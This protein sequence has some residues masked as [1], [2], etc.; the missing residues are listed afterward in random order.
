MPVMSSAKI[1]IWRTGDG[2]Y[3]DYSN[4]LWAGG[5][6]LV[7]KTHGLNAPQRLTFALQDGV[8][9][10]QVP[11]VGNRIRLTTTPYGVTFVGYLISVPE[12]E[13]LGQLPSG[14][15]AYGYHCV[16]V[17]EE[18][19]LEWQTAA[20]F[21]TLPPF[22]NKYQGEIIAE[23][24]TIL[25][26]GLT[27]TNIDNGIL[28]PY[29]RVRPEEG[30][31]DA[32]RR[33]SDRT[34]M[35]FW[36]ANGAAYY[37]FF[38]NLLSANREIDS[39]AWSKS[40]LSVSANSQADENGMMTAERVTPTVGATNAGVWQNLSSVVIGRSYRA[41]FLLKVPSGTVNVRIRLNK[42]SINNA[43][44]T[45]DIVVTSSWAWY[46]ILAT[47]PGDATLVGAMLG[48]DASWV[49]ADGPID[50][51]AILLTGDAD[52]PANPSE[53]DSQFDPAA[54][55]VS[56]VENPVYN[57]VIAVGAIEPQ[58][59]VR[60]YFIGD[61]LTGRFPLKFPMFGA[62]SSKLLEDDF[63]AALDANRWTETD[64]DSAISIAS[65]SLR[66]Q[67]SS[68]SGNNRL[69]AKQGVEIAGVV[70]LRSGRVRFNAA[71]SLL[72]GGLF[73]SDTGLLANCVAGFLAAP[74]GGQSDLRAVVS[75][76]AAGPTYT[77]VAG[78]TYQFA[79]TMNCPVQVRRR[80]PFYSITSQFGGE[81]VS[82]NA[83]VSFSVL[84]LPDNESDKPTEVL[85]YS[86]S[87]SGIAR[88]L[89]FTE[90]AGPVTTPGSAD[91]NANFCLL[92][93][94]IT[95]ELWT[96][97]TADAGYVQR[98]L[99]DKADPE[100]WAS[101]IAGTEGHEL[102]FFQDRIP[103]A[104]EKI[105]LVYR[106][107]GQA[108]VRVRRDASVTLEA[109][110][111]G[112]SG[113]RTAVLPSIQPPPRDSAELERALQAFIDDATT[114]RY[115]GEWE[116]HTRSYSPSTEPLPG[117]LLTVDAPTRHPRFVAPVDS[118]QSDFLFIDESQT[119]IIRHTVHFGSAV[120]LEEELSETEPPENALEGALDTLI[121]TAQVEFA[122]V[123]AAFAA[124]RPDGDFSGTLTSTTAQIDMGAAPS[125]AYEVRKTDAGWGTGATINDVLASDPA[126]QTFTIPRSTRDVL[127]FIKNRDG[128]GL[129][130]RFPT[131]IRLLY[132]LP[133]NAPTA[134][135]DATNRLKPI[136]KLALPGSADDV[137][138]VEIRDSDDTAVL[139]RYEGVA[140][141]VTPDDPALDF[142][143]DNAGAVRS[144]T[145]YA[146]TFNLLGEYS[147]QVAVNI[148]MP[149]P[150]V[151]GLTLDE[152]DQSL[153]WTANADADES[154]VQVATDAGFSSIVAQ[155]RVKGTRFPL[156]V[157]DVVGTRYYRVRHYDEIGA[158]S[159]DSTG[160]PHSYTA[161]GPAAFNNT[162]HVESV[163]FPPAPGTDPTYG[164]P[165]N[166][167]ARAIQDEAWQD[168]IQQTRRLVI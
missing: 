45:Q 118:V 94:P 157:Q 78:K 33:L 15:P 132:P 152:A 22:V 100:A 102:I 49:E 127:A 6:A 154:E 87:I 92:R 18:L 125:S 60:E 124:D 162:D 165:F 133:P 144:K 167:I 59:Y 24:I 139:Y 12:R 166:P 136:I 161:T 17:S 97:K 121:D 10:F 75:G 70:E 74:N 140:L 108:R 81:D 79:V 91:V 28:I 163:G 53:S 2:A 41:R 52:S 48:G 138:G 113:V 58:A 135:V 25:G 16:A 126:T 5:D 66:F 46:E 51:G 39:S 119:D 168:Y 106:A 35:A 73:S 160:S 32:V 137:F 65:N 9:G 31:M 43:M 149:A 104:R 143:W 20:K 115:E 29:F 80:R 164:S 71:S 61:G 21:P 38:G 4:W 47:A 117:K 62:V 40:Q 57:D 64:P 1:E 86:A 123:G 111:A 67:A 42:N 131:A 89:F 134:T 110:R 142:V 56:P 105:K 83:T 109:S 150:T 107:A 50:V 14:S 13:L 84:E 98:R 76:A 122:S 103:D 8:S 11:E 147:S 114:P 85:K 158:G 30:F 19:R 141:A 156:A 23:L 146:Y 90:L 120:R 54:L 93:K 129:V 128:A 7:S 101:V 112:D 27:T 37:R 95:A 63:T 99:G 159:W 88:F 26:G 69:T 44:A 34:Q 151:S 153:R 155:G 72:I 3:T 145:L 82:A 55:S 77:T 148:S 36:T 130:S 96:R 68:V 116:F